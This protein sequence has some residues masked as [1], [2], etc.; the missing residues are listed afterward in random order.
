MNMTIQPDAPRDNSTLQ[1]AVDEVAKSGGGIVEVPAGVY[2]MR[3]ALHL[4]EGVLL[5]GESG[6]MLRKEPS[7]CSALAQV[8]GYGHYEFAV[9]EPEKFEVG[10]GVLLTDDEAGGFYTTQATI[11]AREG[12]WFFIDRPFSHDYHPSRGGLVESLFSI[13]DGH[14]IRGA[15]LQELTLDGNEAETRMLN[16][17]RGGGVFLLGCRDIEMRNIEVSHYNGDAIS[18][19]QCID[20]KVQGCEIHQNSGGGLH[21]GSGSVRYLLSDNRIHDNGGD[22]IYYCLRTT[23]SRCEYNEIYHNGGVGIS[24]GERDTDHLIVRNRIAGNGGAGIEFRAP[25]VQSGDHARVEKNRLAANCRN[26]GEAEIVV[27]A[28]LRDI[29]I[30]GNIIFAFRTAVLWVGENCENI[31]FYD[32]HIDE[33]DIIAGEPVLRQAP[34]TLSEVGPE[35]APVGAARHLG[36]EVLDPQILSHSTVF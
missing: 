3:D 8:C 12:D 15:G 33:S 24:I 32:N 11:T 34:D 22:G 20:I 27:A 16:G 14:N 4:R 13:V 18:F 10:M 26:E 1:R 36:I 25:M 17:C 7:V 19:Q 5:L 29:S 21:P 2:Q 28:G 30:S 9:A 6:V 35:A 23:H 31:S